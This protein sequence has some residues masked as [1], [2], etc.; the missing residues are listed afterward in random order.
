[1]YILTNGTLYCSKGNTS[2]INKTAD[3]M[4]AFRY[5]SEEEANK[6]LLR[7]TH[8]LNGYYVTEDNNNN[9]KV[10]KRKS[11][12]S[13]TR[14]IIYR[15]SKGHCCLCGNF[16]DYE[17]YTIDH[18]IPLAKGGTNELNNLQCACKVCNNI[19]TDV[20]PDEFMDKITQMI[21]F[22]M[23]NKHSKTLGKKIIKMII[24]SNIHRVIKS[25]G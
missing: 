6:E 17:E 10:C 18:I 25:N 22:N 4:Q 2:K 7:A 11:F 8:K 21:I 24:T 19:K 3:I 15:K 5:K 1:M 14:K 13:E 9:Q 23:N 20:L 16:V 12:G